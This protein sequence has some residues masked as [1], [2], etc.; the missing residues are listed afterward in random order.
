MNPTP[1]SVLVYVG[2]DLVG[3][4][5]M[6]LPFVRALR[7][8][9]PDAAI[10][11]CAGKHKSAF[12]DALQPLTVGLIDEV[13]EEAGFDRPLARF[14]HRPLG[15]RYFDW[16][17]DTQRGVAVSFLIRRI[18]HDL[19]IS[20]SANF[21]LSDS[22]PPRGYQR[23]AS[24]VA[25]MLDLLEL[26]SA[27]PPIPGAPLNLDDITRA[28]AAAALPEGPVYIGLAPGAGGRNKCWPLENYIAL[29]RGQI[30][31]GRVPVFILGPAEGE[32][33]ADLK[34]AVPEALFPTVSAEALSP[35]PSPAP[36]VGYSIALGARLAAAVANDAGSGHILAASDAPLVSLFGPT[37]AAKFAPAASKGRVIEAL[38]FG[39]DEMS[40]IP[41]AAVADAV[42][43][44]LA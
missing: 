36:S 27:A 9:C 37:P 32:W 35:S 23:P 16:V 21:M 18:R 13:V 44:L 41:L 31:R 40:A 33:A 29:A 12:A 5:V 25:Q 26:A 6:K 43:A 17:I 11:W 24:M 30:A 2:G 28:K 22:K 14:L 38:S 34:A 20:G 42:D 10:T 7:A 1:R 4:A 39:S 8:A 15:G 19:F 3:D